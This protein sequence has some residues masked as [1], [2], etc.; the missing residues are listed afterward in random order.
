MKAS[1]AKRRESLELLRKMNKL[2]SLQAILAV[3]PQI[4]KNNLLMLR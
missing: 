1:S 3:V 2:I 4:D